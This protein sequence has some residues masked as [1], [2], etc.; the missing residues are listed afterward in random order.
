MERTLITRIMNGTKSEIDAFHL[1]FWWGQNQRRVLDDAIFRHCLLIQ[2]SFCTLARKYHA[3]S[4][5]FL[6]VSG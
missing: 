3:E 4:R 2:I 5:E 1:A 6:D